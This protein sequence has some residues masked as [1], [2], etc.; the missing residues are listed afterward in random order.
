MQKKRNTHLLLPV[1]IA[2]IALC[3]ARGYATTYYVSPSGSDTNSGTSISTP[4]KTVSKVNGKSLSAGDTV[5]FEGGATFSGTTLT[6]KGTGTATSRITYTSYGT[7]KAIIQTLGLNGIVVG[8]PYTTVSNLTVVGDWNTTTN[9]GTT[10]KDGVIFRTTGQGLQSARAD[11]LDV[12]GYGRFGVQLQNNT[13]GARITNCVVH[14]NRNSGICAI[15]GNSG[16]PHKNVY[17]GDCISYSNS[18][19]SSNT[20]GNTGSGIVLGGVDGAVVERCVAYG[21]GWRCSS[22]GGPVGIWSWRSNNVVIQFC[23]A[24]HNNGISA[25]GGGFDID[26]GDTNCIVQYC[27]SHDNAGAGYGLFQY[28]GA[29]QMNNN[30][31]RYNISERDGTKRHGGIYIWNGLDPSTFTNTYVYNNTVYVPS[32][33]RPGLL[34]NG[35]STVNAGIWN[36]IFHVANGAKSIDVS[37]SGIGLKGNCYWHNGGGFSAK[38]NGVT[39]TSMISFRAGTNQEMLNGLPIGLEAAPLFYNGGGGE[40]A[41]RLQQSSPLI[42]AGLD[43][44]ATFGINPGT[45]DFYG[46]AIPQYAAF[47]VGAAEYSQDQ[48][49]YEPPTVVVVDNSD[50]T[51]VTIT[52]TWTVSTSTLGYYGGNYLHDGNASKGSMSVRYTPDLPVAGNYEVFARWTTGTN[53]ATNAPIDIITASG[54]APVQVN[55]QLNNGVWISLGIYSFNSGASGSVLISNAGTNG[56]VIADAVKFERR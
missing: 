25:D 44:Q 10:G 35:N 20:T 28:T 27:Y 2:L 31:V 41:Y 14:N 17:I 52:G 53:R 42:D 3:P 16:Y 24:H 22:V 19:D 43:L 48:P 1:F 9:T 50:L 33:N 54:T 23:E 6:T 47:D 13:D 38:Y 45:Q 37:G 29:P 51:A 21:N 7:G 56:Y 46:V 30:I 18:G 4:W 32:G 11:S 34:M 39:Y 15:A 12:S 40:M 8:T 26:G 49:P 5:C 36:N 55:Q